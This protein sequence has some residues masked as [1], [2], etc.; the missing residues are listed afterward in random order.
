M[1]S[2]I[3]ASVVVRL[4]GLHTIAFICVRVGA[5]GDGYND[6][7]APPGYCLRVSSSTWTVVEG[8]KTVASGSLAV[9]AKTHRLS[10]EASGT[11]LTADV[12]G[13]RVAVA[14]FSSTR[15]H[16]GQVAIGCSFAA[17]SFDDFAVYN[18]APR[19]RVDA[20]PDI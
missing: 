10:L 4:P 6:G 5:T 11:S 17:V 2:D 19:T 20:R 14:N 7:Q 9:A 18:T 15:Y 1:W 12:D 3:N 8:Q 13:V 16:R